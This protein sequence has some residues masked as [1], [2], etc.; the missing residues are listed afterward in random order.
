YFFIMYIYIMNMR[1]ENSGFNPQGPG[2]EDAKWQRSM[3]DIRD[4]KS[5]DQSYSGIKFNIA[6]TTTTN[7]KATG[8]GASDPKVAP[9]AT[10]SADAGSVAPTAYIADAAERHGLYNIPTGQVITVIG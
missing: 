10:R 2:T 8:I 1:I 7:F 3:A 9:L 4:A 5:G 6:P